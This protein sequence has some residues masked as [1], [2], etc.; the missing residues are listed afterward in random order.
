M[1]VVVYG[2]QERQPGIASAVP[3]LQKCGFDVRLFDGK[4]APDF[5][6][7]PCDFA[8]IEGIRSE[9]RYIYEGHRRAKNSPPL[10]ILEYGYIRRA[11]SSDNHDDL[12]WQ[13]SIGD[14]GWVPDYCCSPERF[15]ALG[16]KVRP[17]REPSEDL[18]VV[19]VGDHPGYRE[20]IEDFIWPEIRHWA[21]SAL[22]KIRGKT[23]RRVFWRPHPAVQ[24]SIPGFDGLSLGP[25]DWGRQWA[26]VVH[27]SNVGNEALI[28]GCP[29][30]TD[31]W[32]GYAQASN[33]DLAE[34]E[35][36]RL[37]DRQ[38]YFY[39]LAHAQWTLAEIRSGL[40]FREYIEKG[41]LKCRR[42]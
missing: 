27:N 42:A 16:V 32:A 12:A 40:P 13:V 29:V 7:E 41:A 10:V 37:P 8:V 34:I 36:P 35:A 15:E 22:A 25:M 33:S 21:L 38:D 30:F 26:A 4:G 5:E 3:G 6:P 11:S 19:I 18:P 28:A 39:R 17:L 23:S 1:R 31:G 24:I 9:N 20:N 14:L 2:R